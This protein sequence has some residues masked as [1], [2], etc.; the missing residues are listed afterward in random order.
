[1]IYRPVGLIAL[2]MRSTAILKQLTS[3]IDTVLWVGQSVSRSVVIFWAQ[4]VRAN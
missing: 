1:M 4:T 2:T 3:E